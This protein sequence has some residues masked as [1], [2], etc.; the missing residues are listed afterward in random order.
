MS[1]GILLLNN[2]IMQFLKEKRRSIT[3][4]KG[5]E[6]GRDVTLRHNEIRDLTSIATTKVCRDV[7]RKP[8]LDG[9]EGEISSNC[10]LLRK[11]LL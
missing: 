1:G 4:V 5:Q 2:E 11:I 9:F 6:E 10:V 7:R 3:R 8:R